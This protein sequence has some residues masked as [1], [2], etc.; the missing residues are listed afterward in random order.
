VP[1]LA[2]STVGGG[3]ISLDPRGVEEGLA[4]DP[5]FEL[6]LVAPTLRGMSRIGGRAYIRFDH[7]AESLAG[8][9]YRSVRQVFLERLNV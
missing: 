5:I 8:Q 4:L 6:E 1:S 7:G 9:L 2:L 3:A